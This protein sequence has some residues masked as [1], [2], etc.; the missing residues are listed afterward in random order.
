MKISNEQKRLLLTIARKAIQ[1][2]FED[3]S[4]SELEEMD[5]L[6]NSKSGVFVTLTKNR[7]LRGCIGFATS[8]VPLRDSLLE[9][10]I[11]AAT[12]D[13]RFPSI[14]SNEIDKLKIEISILSE[15]YKIISYD[16]IKVGEHG[17][18]LSEGKHRGLL[19]PQVPLEHNLNKDE[20]LSALCNKAGLPKKFWKEKMLNLKAF[21]ATVFSEEQIGLENEKR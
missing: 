12:K 20:Y 18:I 16:E 13:P 19:L 7:K 6:L 10:A 8:D 1:N 3:I 21:T 17:L 2:I 15:P 9:A 14:T 5:E 11:L 4:I